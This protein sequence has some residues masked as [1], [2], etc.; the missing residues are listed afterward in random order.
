MDADRILV[1][2]GGAIVQEGAFHELKDQ[3]GPF[4][5][6]LAAAGEDHA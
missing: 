2:Q 6:L 5:E 1:L 3:P 4:R